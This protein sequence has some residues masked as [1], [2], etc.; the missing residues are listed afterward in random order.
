MRS[1]V[2]P[3]LE[4]SGAL[5][6]LSDQALDNGGP[7][8]RA[9]EFRIVRD[10]HFCFG[11]DPNPSTCV[12]GPEIGPGWTH[13]APANA[14][15]AGLAVGS[16]IVEVEWDGSQLPGDADQSNLLDFSDAIYIWRHILLG[17][18]TPSQGIDG[19]LIP[20]PTVRTPV[21]LREARTLITPGRC[22]T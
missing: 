6:G 7:L 18:P 1:E 22:Y 10:D 16:H 12:F 17:D 4:S 19:L 9:G 20:F 3:E 14:R 11:G 5:W 2:L 8:A 13:P 21:S 15:G